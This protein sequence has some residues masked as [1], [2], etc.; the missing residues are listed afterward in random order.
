MNK[1]KEK[2]LNLIIKSQKYTKTDMLY[3]T[4]GGFWLLVGKGGLTLITLVSM[5]AFARF[6]PI[7]EFGTY[8]YI[9]SL[10]GLATI[11]T[12]PGIN[13]TLIRSIA[14][15][16]E[17]TLGLA[18]KEKTRFAM[19]GSLVLFSVAL[20]Y[21]FNENFLLAGSLAIAGIFL[22]FK[23]VW[24][25]FDSF[26]LGRKRFDIQ[27]IYKILAGLI[28][29]VVMVPT[30]YLTN[31][32]LIIIFA[33]F[34][35]QTISEGIFL[36][37][38]FRARTNDEKDLGAISFGKKLTGIKVI[39]KIAANIDSIIIWKFLGPAHVAIYSFSYLPIKQ[40]KE[41]FL[42]KKLAL[43]KLSERT[44]T[45]ELKAG[46]VSKLIKL[47][48]L[49][50][51]ISIG[52]ALIAPFVYQILFPQYME[53]VIYFQVLTVLLALTPLQLLH[54]TYL[55][56]NKQKEVYI[57]NLTSPIIRIILFLPL[58]PLL[59]IWGVVIGLLVAHI[60][61]SLISLYLFSRLPTVTEQEIKSPPSI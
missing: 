18:V 2:I 41:A 9:L 59:G 53:S 17:G 34:L 49:T 24:P 30:I 22:P 13:T 3:I 20:W 6:L 4:K 43:P 31:N 23:E 48:A 27:S 21:A 7:E 14:K 29:L 10:V 36:L 51:P 58:V 5:I 56:Q 50:I 11:F 60:I 26:W 16:Y 35:M 39:N 57:I 52:L 32:V 42:I 38:T 47:F 40:T 1:T 55:S 8:K 37:K 28:V 45:K 15:G 54:A 33:L 44:L 25:I 46:I 19:M 61:T 12:L